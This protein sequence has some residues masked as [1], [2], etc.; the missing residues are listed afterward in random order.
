MKSKISKKWY[1]RNR[2]RVY[3][4]EDADLWIRFRALYPKAE[5]SWHELR[6]IYGDLGLAEFR[7]L[8]ESRT[9]ALIQGRSIKVVEDIDPETITD[10]LDAGG[11]WT[12]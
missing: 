12:F 1:A 5:T 3:V 8:L 2:G 10:T 7:R 11:P 4:F 6:V 9:V